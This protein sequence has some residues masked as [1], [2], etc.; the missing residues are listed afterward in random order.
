MIILLLL[1]TGLTYALSTDLFD[2]QA[3]QDTS[4]ENLDTEDDTTITIEPAQTPPGIVLDGTAD[5]DVMMNTSEL[6]GTIKGYSGNDI[7]DAGS[8]DDLVYGGI[9]DDILYGAKNYDQEVFEQQLAEAPISLTEEVKTLFGLEHAISGSTN[10]DDGCD[11][12]YGGDG[13]DQIFFGQSD[14]VYGSKDQ[15]IFNLVLEKNGSGVAHLMDYEKGEPINLVFDHDNTYQYNDLE[16]SQIN[17]NDA[18]ISIGD[19]SV[20]LIH[21]AFDK[22]DST[23][24]TKF[25]T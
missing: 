5:T 20:L 13:D 3:D 12:L 9:G 19:K 21:G 15:D 22:I 24:I 14:T 6:D 17:G 16:I 23:T 10:M 1:I 25:H 4:E 7:I 2:D 18:L 11:T 8:G